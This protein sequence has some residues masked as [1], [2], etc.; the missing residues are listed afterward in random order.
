MTTSLLSDNFLIFIF[1]PDFSFVMASSF[2]IK[3]ADDLCLKLIQILCDEQ[4]AGV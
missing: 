1:S 2:S 4:R 3:F